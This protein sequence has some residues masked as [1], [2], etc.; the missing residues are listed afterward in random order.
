MIHYDEVKQLLQEADDN[1]LTM[2][3]TV[4]PRSSENINSNPG[5][6]IW[7]KNTLRDV[8]KS[9]DEGETGVWSDVRARAET[10]L[11]GYQ[12]TG[13][14]LA[15]L[16][17]PSFE[18]TFDLPFPI[19]NQAS[20]GKPNVMPLLWALDEYEPYLIALVDQ[21]EA[22]FFLSY[23]GEVGFQ[24]TV[25][26]NL[27]IGEGPQHT[28]MPT[29][30]S[31][32][33]GSKKDEV[34]DRQDEHIAGLHRDVVAHLQKLTEQHNVRRIV[35]GGSEQAAHQVRNFMPEKM[36]E[37]VVAVLP[38]PILT[39]PREWNNQVQAAA[40]E[41]ERAQETKLV[42]EI[43]DFAKSGGRG[44]L[45]WKDV[46]QALQMQRVELL[47]LPWPVVDEAQAT[48]LA[49]KTFASGGRIELVHDEAAALLGG[50]GGLGARLYYA[51]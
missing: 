30:H 24:D 47:V 8:T 7:T 16:V 12:P 48:E 14:G 25:E 20:F 1:T 43:I 46:Q 42:G 10:L 50:E 40:L 2:Y 26:I 45:G 15:L 4:D 38:I 3:L 22:R 32:A 9:Q 21:T 5:W 49:L 35:L 6:R 18:R 44:A 31:V 33:R 36:A 13:K 37:A 27:N 28:A 41:Y 23:L 11:E 19:E 29:S 39:Y 34:Q 17:S 51:L